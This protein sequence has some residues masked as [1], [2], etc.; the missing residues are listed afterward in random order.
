M[1]TANTIDDSSDAKYGKYAGKTT[2][3]Y[4]TSPN[5]STIPLENEW[6]AIDS[7]SGK[8][9]VLGEALEFSGAIWF[10]AVDQAGNIT[11]EG[12]YINTENVLV[13]INLSGDVN[14]TAKYTPLK[15]K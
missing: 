11:A 14:A 2:L 15:Q 4:G 7:A 3:Y 13:N 9:D 12:T 5:K 6:K 1:V 10:R 8:F